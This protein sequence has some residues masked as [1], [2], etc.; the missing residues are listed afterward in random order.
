VYI[1]DLAKC[2]G[3]PLHD[4]VT[5]LRAGTAG[6]EVPEQPGVKDLLH[7]NGRNNPAA[8]RSLPN[9]IPAEVEIDGDG[10]RLVSWPGSTDQV[11][12]SEE[13]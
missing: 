3:E 1:G 8:Q 4:E 13:A 7:V 11:M 6:I 5:V 10:W 12:G 9:C 2:P